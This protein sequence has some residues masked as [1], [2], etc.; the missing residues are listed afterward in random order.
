MSLVLY[1]ELSNFSGKCIDSGYWVPFVCNSS[2]SFMAIFLKLYRCFCH[3]L[4]ICMWFRYNP[5]INFC[6][7]FF[8]LNLVIFQESEL[9]VGALSV[10]L[11]QQFYVILFETLPVL[12]HGL[13][14]CM[15]FGY[16]YQINFCHIF[17]I[18][19]LVIFAS[20]I[21]SECIVGILC[22]QLLLQFYEIFLKL[23]RCFCHGLKMCMWFGYYNPQ[24]KLF[25]LCL[26]PSKKTNENNY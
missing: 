24:I 12:W 4:K 21:L 25:F 3:G 7:F 10:Q 26:I 15:W 18:L 13:K 14:M 22:G 1:F 2:Y 9:I 19:K 16:N 6:H 5:Q 20:W 17:R 8:I 11:C 23:Y